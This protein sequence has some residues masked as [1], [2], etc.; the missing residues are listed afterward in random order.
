MKRCP[1]CG[2]TR[3]G[4]TAHVTQDWLVDADG[5]FMKQLD[6]CVEV[7]HRPDDDDVW[8][9]YECGYSAAGREFNVGGE[10][11]EHH[12]EQ[13]VE[14]VC[15]VCGATIEL[16]GGDEDGYGILYMR[17]KCDKCGASGRASFEN[18]GWAFVE[19]E[20]DGEE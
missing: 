7:T 15:P 18:L 14:D 12:V 2:G 19:H 20:L 16:C 13:E 5:Q 6:S 11:V 9:C 3:F 4:V 1:K 10:H 8:D 17:W